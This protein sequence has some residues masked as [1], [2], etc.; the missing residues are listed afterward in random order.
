MGKVHRSKQGGQW[1]NT[2]E[3]SGGGLNFPI[4]IPSR[5]YPRKIRDSV[6]SICLVSVTRESSAELSLSQQLVSLM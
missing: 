6:I 2:G 1:E 5:R 4:F 3:E